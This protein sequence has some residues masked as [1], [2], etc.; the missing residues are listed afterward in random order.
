MLL[1]DGWTIQ[2][3]ESR[4]DVFPQPQLCLHSRFSLRLAL[5]HFRLR[6]FKRLEI[7]LVRQGDRILQAGKDL[8][9]VFQP[10]D[11]SKLVRIKND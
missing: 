3:F 6:L 2:F 1:I 4:T 9:Y 10:A 5:L 11:E 7:F 8:F